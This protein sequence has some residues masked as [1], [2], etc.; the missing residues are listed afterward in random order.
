MKES[1]IQSAIEQYL[2]YQENLGKLIYIK[3]NSGAMPVMH[4]D[5]RSYFRFGKP[6][7]P[8]F[9]I[10]LPQGQVIHMEVKNE[11]G[12]LNDNQIN[13]KASIEKL[14][15]SYCVVRSVEGAENILKNLK[16]IKPDKTNY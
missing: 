15:H 3:N 12:K 8:D 6:G 16:P 2:K 5:K 14:G 10:F 1:L 13:Y 11:K 9:L 7:S 4:G